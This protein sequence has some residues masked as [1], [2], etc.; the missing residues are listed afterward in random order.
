MRKKDLEGARREYGATR[1]LE[2]DMAPDPFTQLDRWLGEVLEHV[3]EPGAMVLATIDAKGQ[4]R[5]RT[6]LLKELDHRGL[7]F[8]TNRNSQKGKDLAAHPNAALVFPWYQMERQVT[9]RGRVEMMTEDESDLIWWSRP[10]EAQIA[11]RASAQSSE[12]PSREALEDA[13]RRCLA[14]FEDEEEI[15]RP[16]HWGG[17]W[18]RPQEM[19]FWQ[20]GPYRLHDRLLYIVADD[21]S[22]WRLIRLSP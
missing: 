17:Y 4:P 12:I 19:E 15:P 22:S 16:S 11:A 7:G 8:A 5:S 18:I 6:V 2:G 20:G 9:A 21:Q 13:Y 10:R 1:L 3:H 14:E